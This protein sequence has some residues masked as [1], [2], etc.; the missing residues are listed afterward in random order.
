[1]NLTQKLSQYSNNKFDLPGCSLPKSAD[2]YKGSSYKK[3]SCCKFSKYTNLY[4]NDCLYNGHSLKISTRELH[5]LMEAIRIEKVFAHLVITSSKG[6]TLYFSHSLYWLLY[7][8]ANSIIFNLYRIFFIFYSIV[9]I[10]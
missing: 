9:E 3:Y 2:I 8:S 10:D 5:P 1:M 7:S 4:P 6:S